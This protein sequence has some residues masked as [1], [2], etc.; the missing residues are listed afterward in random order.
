MTRPSPP[1][2]ATAAR[3]SWHRRRRPG[4]KRPDRFRKLHRTVGVGAALFL[5]VLSLTGFLLHHPG[6]LGSASEKTLSFAVDPQDP[7]HLFRGTVSGLYA[8]DNGGHAW[9][10][11][12]MLFTAER[13]VDIAFVPGNPRRVYVVLEDLGIIRSL[14]G[15]V[16]WQQIPLG[17]VPLIEGVRLQKIG[18]GS[19]ESLRI[20]TSGGL[21]FSP[22][23]GV[24]WTPVGDQNP[25]G[26]D[27]YTLVHQIH[28]GY[29]FDTWLPSFYDIVACATIGLTLTGLFLWWRSGGKLRRK[30]MG[31]NRIHVQK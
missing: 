29:I 25:P 28:T 19:D 18:I 11:V 22:D 1:Q 6:L 14:D 24:T 17:F 16:V 12:P 13:A 15:G 8:S 20:W 2:S 26:Q 27:L 5:V 4:E 7:N 10:E 3:T 9:Y 23:T 30:K 31:R 21:L